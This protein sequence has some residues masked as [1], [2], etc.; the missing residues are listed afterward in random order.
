MA[1]M[2]SIGMVID[3]ML[4]LN[5][6]IAKY[7]K[8]CTYCCHVRRASLIE[9]V[10]GMPW[11]KT[12]RTQYHS[13]LSLPDKGCAIKGLVVCNNWDIEPLDLLNDLTLGCYQPSPEVWIFRYSV[14]WV[15]IVHSYLDQF[16]D[17]QHYLLDHPLPW[18][19]VEMIPMFTRYV[20]IQIWPDIR[21][22][23]D[24]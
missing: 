19:T 2:L 22:T 10:W 11:P 23:A 8:S 3:L 18:N 5:R 17:M 12:G 1:H 20:R 21:I 9:R 6:V 14:I 15:T 7:V 13:Q 4:S 16:M 24:F